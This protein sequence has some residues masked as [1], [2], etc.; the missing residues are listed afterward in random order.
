[1]AEFSE[2]NRGRRDSFPNRRDDP[3]PVEI[4][5]RN[6]LLDILRFWTLAGGDCVGNGGAIFGS[7]EQT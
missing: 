1:M 2:T 4:I 3:T 7:H 5:L 6:S